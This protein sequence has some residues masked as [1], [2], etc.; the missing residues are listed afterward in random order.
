V[1]DSS[2]LSTEPPYKTSISLIGQQVY[3]FMLNLTLMTPE[4][5]HVNACMCEPIG[6]NRTLANK[7]V[8]IK[9]AL[10]TSTSDLVG[11][12]ERI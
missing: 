12:G 1:Y 11:R 10:W 6:R 4:D 8:K 2:T 3:D 5:N 7:V 9:K